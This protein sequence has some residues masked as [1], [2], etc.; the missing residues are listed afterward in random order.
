MGPLVIRMLFHPLVGG[1]SNVFGSTVG[2]TN[3]RNWIQSFVLQGRV[4]PRYLLVNFLIGQPAQ[5]WMTRRVISNLP[6]GL[7]EGSLR[8]TLLIDEKAIVDLEPETLFEI[9]DVVDNRGEIQQVKLESGGIW[10]TVESLGGGQ[11]FEVQTRNAIGG[12]RGTVFRAHQDKAEEDN[13]GFS[14]VEGALEVRDRGGHVLLD[15]LE[16]GRQA[17]VGR[18]GRLSR[19]NF[20]PGLAQ[21]RYFKTFRRSVRQKSELKKFVTWRRGLKRGAGPGGFRPG[22]RIGGGEPDGGVG[23][24]VDSPDG[25]NGSVGR[26]GKI[27]EARE[28]R[29]LNRGEGFRGGAGAE[30]RDEDDIETGSGESSDQPRFQSLRDRLDDRL[31]KGENSVGAGQSVPGTRSGFSPRDLGGDPLSPKT[32]PRDRFRDRLNSRP[33]GAATARERINDSNRLRDRRLRM[34]RGQQTRFPHAPGT[35]SVAHPK[36]PVVDGSHRD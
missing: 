2:I 35:S 12:V 8:C 34:R 16:S 28:K 30:G 29:N 25:V 1:L 19:R 27:R 6:S 18:Q 15:R 22:R 3:P 23:N 31:G 4:I 11:R 26:T 32:T 33:D 7:L 21:V 24:G 10:A 9:P 14:M 5:S 36:L 17:L 20:S 13:G